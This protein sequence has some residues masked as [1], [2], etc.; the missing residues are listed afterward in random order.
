MR[1]AKGQF[2]KGCGAP[3]NGFQKGHP[4]PKGAGS[5]KKGNLVNK[6]RTPWNKGTKGIMKAWNKGMGNSTENERIRFSDE[7]KDWVRSVLE[8]D[9]FTCQKSGLR[10]G[11][12]E[13]HHINNFSEFPEL[14]FERKNG[15][16]LRKEI[17]LEFHKLYGWKNNTMEQ[18]KEFLNNG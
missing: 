13:V 3:K 1:N 8:R 4:K 15:I 17:H 18:L 6:G 14:R 10:G 7:Y 2:I 16:T 5:F 12:L 11:D 9:N